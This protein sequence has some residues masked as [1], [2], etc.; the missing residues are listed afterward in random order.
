MLLLSKGY[1]GHFTDGTKGVSRGRR[2]IAPVFSGTA[3]HDT[4]ADPG[5]ETLSRGATNL[6]GPTAELCGIPTRQ[7]IG[8][9]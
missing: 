6:V 4:A 1:L 9:D 8:P 5:V 2:Y 7:G 3:G